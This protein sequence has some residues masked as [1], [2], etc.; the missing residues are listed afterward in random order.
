MLTWELDQALTNLEHARTLVAETSP[1]PATLQVIESLILSTV[2]ILE[3]EALTKATSRHK[4]D[5]EG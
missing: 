1:T 3:A 5:R 4:F 2:K